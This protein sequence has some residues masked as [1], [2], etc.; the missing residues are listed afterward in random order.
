MKTSGKDINDDTMKLLGF[1]RD[2]QYDNPSFN[3]PSSNITYWIDDNQINII[4]S[5]RTKLSIPQIIIKI[6]GNVAYQTK[7]RIFKKVSEMQYEYNSFV[8]DL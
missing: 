7:N 4:T 8:P 1:H 3:S 6:A 2:L 5:K